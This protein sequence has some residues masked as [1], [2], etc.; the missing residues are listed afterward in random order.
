MPEK[1]Y[2]LKL[3]GVLLLGLIALLI[4]FL[5]FIILLP[6]IVVTALGVI[7]LAIVFIIIWAVIYIAMVIGAAI[8]YFFKPMEVSKKDKKYSVAKT[9]ESGMREKGKS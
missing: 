5:L 9:K 1:T 2:F 4:A 6:L 7:L 3:G 8:Y